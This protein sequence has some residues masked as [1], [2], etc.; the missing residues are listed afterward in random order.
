MM[1]ICGRGKDDYL[2]DVVPWPTK[3]D[4]KFK[5]WKAENK[6]VISWLINSMNNGIEENIVLYET[7]QE[8]WEAVRETYLDLEDTM[9]AFEIDGI[10][11]DLY[12]GDSFVTQYFNL[13]TRYWQQPDMNCVQFDS[14][15]KGF[16]VVNSVG[17]CKSLCN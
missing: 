12:Q 11:H 14:W 15:S 7:V 10:L 13:L 17:L 6:M 8:I 3:E 9:E 2:I 5:G 1:F 16:L 4:P